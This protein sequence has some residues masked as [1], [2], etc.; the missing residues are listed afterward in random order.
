MKGTYKSPLS[1]TGKGET[2]Q[3]VIFEIKVVCNFQE[4]HTNYY[5]AFCYVKKEYPDYITSEGHPVL[6]NFQ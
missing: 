1:E 3:K 5:D 2:M 6:A 4:F